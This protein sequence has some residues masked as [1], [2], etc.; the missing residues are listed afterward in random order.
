MAEMPVP[1]ASAV[2]LAPGVVK[3]ALHRSSDLMLVVCGAVALRG[4]WIEITRDGSWLSVL[5]AGILV[6]PFFFYGFP[7]LLVLLL[8][9]SHLA[10]VR[11]SAWRDPWTVALGILTLG[12]TAWLAFQFR[13]V[14]PGDVLDRYAGRAEIVFAFAIA[15]GLLLVA[16]RFP[17]MRIAAMRMVTTV[18]VI[19]LSLAWFQSRL[20]ESRFDREDKSYY[21]AQLWAARNTAPGSLFLVDPAKH[22][23]WIAFSHR[24]SF[25]NVRDWIVWP[26]TYSY[27]P[28]EFQEGLRRLSEFKLDYRDFLGRSPPIAGSEALTTAVSERFY[29]LTPQDLERL[30][31]KYGIKYVLYFRRKLKDPLQTA[32]RA[33][34]NEDIVIVRLDAPPAQKV[35]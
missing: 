21:Q 12:A 35:Q 27:N 31:G 17:A 33:Y 5:A 8:S 6:S 11:G 25:G 30:A 32:N 34:E 1:W 3:L 4:L 15:A 7:L 16:G 19:A 20:G 14:S 18:A 13:S 28:G 9:F 10:R 23:G 29:A 22:Y 26:T 24:P 2:P